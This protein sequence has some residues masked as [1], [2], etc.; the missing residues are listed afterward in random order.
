MDKKIKAVV[1]TGDKEN[2]ACTLFFVLFLSNQFLGDFDP[3][4]LASFD[5]R[6]FHEDELTKNWKKIA[7][8]SKPLLAAVNGNALGVGFELALSCDIIYAG[9]ES[10]FGHPAVTNSLIPGKQT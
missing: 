6:Q 10:Q 4:Q 9:L 3:T 7:E 8:F 1:I 2:F 5:V